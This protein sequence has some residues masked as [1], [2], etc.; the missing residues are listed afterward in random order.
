M[1]PRTDSMVFNYRNYMKL[2]RAHEIIRSILRKNLQSATM[3]GEGKGGRRSN[4]QVGE[5]PGADRREGAGGR[6]TLHDVVLAPAC[7]RPGMEK[8]V[9][10]NT[11]YMSERK[12]I[13]VRNKLY[14][15]KIQV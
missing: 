7:Q 6:V 8:G 3:P 12:R 9:S 13:C 5:L 10:R 4:K 2:P 1:A 14:C 11:V 15:L